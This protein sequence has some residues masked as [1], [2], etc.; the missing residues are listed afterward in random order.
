MKKIIL[1]LIA[2]VLAM[3]APAF[4]AGLDIR[5]EIPVS[6]I[7]EGGTFALFDGEEAIDE[8]VIAPG[9]TESLCV[10]LDSLDYF[11]F[12]VRQVG[13]DDDM[14]DYDGTVYEVTVVTVLNEDDT[15]YA[16]I[17]VRNAEGGEKAERIVFENRLKD[18]PRTGDESDLLLWSGVGIGALACSIL[19][20][21]ITK[22]KG[23]KN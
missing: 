5:A 17:S 9:G 20:L 1:L 19:T 7:G 18:V 15:P 16:C 22:R 23:E 21:V 13:M 10:R 3:S 12:T 6:C 8:K 4:A 11:S 14:V 2:A